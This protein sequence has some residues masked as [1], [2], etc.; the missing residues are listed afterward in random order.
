MMDTTKMSRQEAASAVYGL[1]QRCQPTKAA[2]ERNFSMLN[3]L[4]AKDRNFLTKNIMHN[5]CLH[6]NLSIKGAVTRSDF[7]RC[8]QKLRLFAI[9]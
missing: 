6:Y 8:E 1:G 9:R 2:V 3:K 5:T 7:G 4:L